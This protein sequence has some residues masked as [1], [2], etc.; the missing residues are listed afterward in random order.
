MRIYRAYQLT[1]EIANVV[2]SLRFIAGI[3]GGDWLTN[4]RHETSVVLGTA[5]RKY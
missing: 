1:H 3:A 5:R 4:R 2:S